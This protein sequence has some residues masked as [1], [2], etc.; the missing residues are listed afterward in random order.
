MHIKSL[1]GLGL[2]LWSAAAQAQTAPAAA[3]AAAAGYITV[4]TQAVQDEEDYTG[5]VQAV[6][7]VHL[8]ARVTGFL[9]SQDFTEGGTVS[10]GQ[11]LYVIEQPPYQAAV[12]QAQAV[13]AQAQAQARLAKI[14]LWRAQAL[15]HSAAGKQEDVDTAQAAFDSDNAAVLSAQA[16]LNVAQINLGYTEI[17]APVAG[18]IGATT[19]TPGNVV[20][21][22]SG[23][24]ATIVSADPIYVSF[25]LPTQEALKYRAQPGGLDVAL[26][27]PDGST[28]Q[29]TGK[30]DFINNQVDASTDTL[31]WRAV[32]ANPAQALID[33]EY[34]T[35]ILRQHTP[36]PEIV[37]P[38]AAIIADQ[39]GDY[40]LEI[41]PGNVITRHNVTLGVQ[42][43]TSAEVLAG[44]APGDEVVVEGIQSLQP[45]LTASPYKVQK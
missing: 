30:V 40:V 11:V 29:Q 3:A 13:L 5:H 15:L 12:Q 6:S 41:G 24:L 16:Q 7:L 14:T 32:I 45:G 2:L 37:L 39:L 42:T 19:V 10:Q 18:I 43:G 25:A 38:L 44:V 35:I 33:G 9:E 34:V 26:R 28:Y 20:G 31:T 23:V 8:Q 27:L 21:P 36:K 1:A 17:R 22:S 4:Q